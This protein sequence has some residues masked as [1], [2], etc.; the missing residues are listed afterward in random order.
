V[1]GH[2]EGVYLGVKAHEGAV[3]IANLAYTSSNENLL[4]ISQESRR[5]ALY[6]QLVVDRLSSAQ[7]HVGPPS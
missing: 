2:A 4:M 1:P 7:V 5:G 6:S 3:K